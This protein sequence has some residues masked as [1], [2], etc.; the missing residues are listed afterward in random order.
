MTSHEQRM[1]N[2]IKEKLRESEHPHGV[3]IYRQ[4]IESIGPDPE[5]AV[6]MFLWLKAN[7]YWYG[8]CHWDEDNKERVLLRAW[9]TTAW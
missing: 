5:A 4:Q 8:E 1:R 6:A 9:V 2:F 3:Y 7:H